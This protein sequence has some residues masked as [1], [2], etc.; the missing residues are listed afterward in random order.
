MLLRHIEVAKGNRKGRGS[1]S[2]HR[3]L[4]RA[5]TVIKS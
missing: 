4:T 2:R 3:Q 5:D 1:P